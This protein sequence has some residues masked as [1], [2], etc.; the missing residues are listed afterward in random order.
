MKCLLK[1]YDIISRYLDEKIE[2]LNLV[3]TN[4]SCS[5]MVSEV[6]IIKIAMKIEYLLNE[7]T[8]DIHHVFPSGK[9]SSDANLY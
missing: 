2:K 4:P 5:I 3:P 1:I 7:L 6:A 9:L 8:L